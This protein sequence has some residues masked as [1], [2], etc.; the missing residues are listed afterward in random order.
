[1]K[2]LICLSTLILS[3]SGDQVF[4]TKQDIAALKRAEFVCSTDSRYRE[5]PCIKAFIKKDI[6]VY[7]VICG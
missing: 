2:T 5:Q 4:Q 6:G 1:M 3:Y 7:N